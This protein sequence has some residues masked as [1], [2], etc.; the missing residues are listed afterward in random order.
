MNQEYEELEVVQGTGEILE[1]TTRSGRKA[2]WKEKKAMNERICSMFQNIAVRRAEHHL[3]PLMSGATFERL[4]DCGTFLQFAVDASSE[5]RLHK[6]N[7]CGVRLCPMCQWRRSL[8]QF[9]VTQE[10]VTW[11]LQQKPETR[12]LFLTVTVRNCVPVDLSVTLD[13]LMQ[14]F[15][16]MVNQNKK[17]KKTCLLKRL[18]R[19]L[20]GSSRAVEVTYNTRTREMHP[21]IHAILAVQPSY[22]TNKNNYMTQQQWVQLWQEAARLD[23]APSVDVRAIDATSPKI[24]AEASKYSAKLSN[25]VKQYEDPEESELAETALEA[26]YLALKGRRLIALSGFFKDAQKALKQE[27]VENKTDLI[28]VD[29]EQDDFKPVEY[30]LFVW[31]ACVGAYVC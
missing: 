30:Q 27:D 7:F 6:A 15:S 28:H 13:N 4:R 22:F 2:P 20:L 9:H 17:Q 8:A 14:G 5:K 29:D 16:R 26:M 3:A 24:V 25:I 31:R 18:H 11:M 23:Y 12:F 10:Q 19:S 1:D 21:H